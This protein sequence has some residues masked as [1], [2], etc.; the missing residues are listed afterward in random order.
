MLTFENGTY[1]IDDN[2]AIQYT[3]ET[4]NEDIHTHSFIELVYVIRGSCVHIIDGR[5]Y[6]MT[7]GCLLLINYKQK[8]SFIINKQAT[9]VNILIKPE[10]F[11]EN[12]VQNDGM[13]SMLSLKDF[14]EFRHTI[15]RDNCFLKFDDPQKQRIEDIIAFMGEELDRAEEGYRLTVRSALHILFTMIFRKMSLPMKSEIYSINMELL[16][17]ISVH[18]GEHI[19]LERL[20]RDCNY[21]PSHFSRAFKKFAGMTL[22]EFLDNVRMEK[23]KYLIESTQLPIGEI[24]AN[25]GYGNPSRFH[26]LFKKKYGETPLQYRKRKNN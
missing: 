17:Y 4:R 20:A 7:D 15:H 26:T 8:H 23:A 21:S 16:S 13:F 24:I 22:T 9:Y 18:C 19:T 6:P 1:Y 11:G 14:A 2:I 10:I 25:V 3:T 12:L 5:E